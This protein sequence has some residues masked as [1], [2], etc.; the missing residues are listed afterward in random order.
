MAGKVRLNPRGFD[1]V[2][3]SG[4]VRAEV[5]R[6]AERVADNVRGL[7]I[8]VEGLPGDI[9]LPVKV[10]EQTTDRARAQV[11][12][13]HPS[14]LAVEAKHGALGKAALEAGLEAND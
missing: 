6:L 2:A 10:V 9:A 12:L 1:A 13:A 7:N 8:R 3:K 5:N 4:A 11:Q 14:G